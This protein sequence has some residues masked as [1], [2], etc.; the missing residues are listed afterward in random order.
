MWVQAAQVL[1]GVVYIFLSVVMA[2][3]CAFCIT[4]LVP[5]SCHHGTTSLRGRNATFWF[6]VEIFCAIQDAHVHSFHFDDQYYT[7]HRYGKAQAAYEQSMH[8]V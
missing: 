6:V 1:R 3:V 5:N 2:G 7:Y 4:T 8:V